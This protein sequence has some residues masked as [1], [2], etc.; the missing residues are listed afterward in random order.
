MKK[1]A[2]L[3]LFFCF[4]FLFSQQKDDKRYFPA[5]YILKTS[6]DTIRTRIRNVGKFSNT[7]YYIATIMFKMKM[8]DD[9]GVETWV[10]PKMLNI[11]KL[12]TKTTLATNIMR[13]REEWRL[14]A[15]LLRFC[16][17]AKT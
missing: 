15:A 14:K 16:M 9:N 17:R 2:F 4:G 7:K 5:E 3:L 13:P 11:S 10:E 6:S 8:R 12:Q 1:T